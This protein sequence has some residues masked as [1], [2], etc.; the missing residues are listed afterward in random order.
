MRPGVH[1]EEVLV[2]PC[3]GHRL[4]DP[5]PPV[6]R[7][8]GRYAPTRPEPDGSV[9]EVEGVAAIDL[10]VVSGAPARHATCDGVRLIT[11]RAL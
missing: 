5:I 10:D 3:G 2:D 9:L 4:R 8:T 7:P 6:R 11:C 1:E